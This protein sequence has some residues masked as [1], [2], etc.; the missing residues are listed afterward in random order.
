MSKH[1][2]VYQVRGEVKYA[3]LH[4]VMSHVYDLPDLLRFNIAVT[5]SG[6]AYRFIDVASVN[7]AGIEELHSKVKNYLIK[8][9]SRL[10]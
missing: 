6:K 4:T 9:D 2:K 10:S 7:L 1:K 5:P 8:D 3:D